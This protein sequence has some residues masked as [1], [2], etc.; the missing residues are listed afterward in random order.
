MEC[1]ENVYKTG[2]LLRKI[3]SIIVNCLSGVTKMSKNKKQK[4]IKSNLRVI[5][6]TFFVTMLNG[7]IIDVG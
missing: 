1:F 2:I 7:S 5:L 4:K 6:K 3:H